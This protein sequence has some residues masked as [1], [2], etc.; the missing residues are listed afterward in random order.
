MDTPSVH[1]ALLSRRALLGGTVG[2]LA[3]VSLAACGS[4]SGTAGGKGRGGTLTVG[5]D[6]EPTTLDP[7]LSSAISSDRNVLN[8]FYDTL[9]RQDRDGSFVPALADRWTEDGRTVT[10][11][12]REGVTFH[13]G[14]PFDA[15]AAA[16]NLRRVI[17]PATRSTKAA[18]LK[19]VGS[20]DVVDARTLRLTLKA[21]DP[22]LLIHLAHEPG[23]MASPTAVKAGDYGRKPVGTGPFVFDA[24]RSKVQLTGKRNPTYWRRATDGSALPRLE[25][26]VFRFVTDT[27]VLRAEVTTG[28]VQ[29]VRTL[30][31]EEFNQLAGDKQIT[32]TDT[33]V[34]RSYYV[35]LNVT[36]APFNDPKVR[37]AFAM[38]IDR[39]GVGKAAAGGQYDLAP[40]FAT[41]KD[42]FYDPSI[43]PPALDPAGAKTA[44]GG[45]P[46][47]ITVVARRRAP[48]PTIAE[49][50]QS[51][52][53]AA[54][55][56]PKVEV[57]EA[58]TQLDRMR[59]QDF[60]AALLV[61][62]I[63]RL[64]PSL[65][66]DPYFSS[67]GSNNWSGLADS[68]LDRLLDTAAAS[69]DRA[70]RKQAYVEVQKRIV[71]EN[72]WVFLHQPKSP[73]IH[74]AKLSGIVLDVDGQWRLDEAALA[75]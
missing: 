30:P 45:T 55:F 42:W 23:M 36:R 6:N 18:A 1:P 67:R 40:S 31:P 38:A 2:A 60:D 72:Y 62:D 14:T 59:K 32:M 9:L 44:L 20:V 35:A 61:I 75:S 28:G 54:G 39:E 48:D 66:F 56:A 68:T 19:N 17:D 11:T 16:F 5:F 7:A 47:P 71:D 33:G 52:L 8:L 13:D 12:L 63:P 69:E 34:R 21:S 73:L 25:Q 24:W 37:A 3:A 74:S 27:K 29:L 22:L 51:Q 49:L 53:T 10:F 43:T 58:Q 41:A 15:E 57:L 65:S 46:V 50:L 26:V 70:V 4:D 64:D